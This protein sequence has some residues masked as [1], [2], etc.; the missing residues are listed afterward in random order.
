MQW[1]G[2]QEILINRIPADSNGHKW[3]AGQ[4][5]KQVAAI[6]SH[7]SSST[8]HLPLLV[9]PHAE[10]NRCYRNPPATKMVMVMV[11]GDG[12]NTFYR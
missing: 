1:M 4:A 5:G 8:S 11:K 9:S 2:R 10:Q 6:S 12:E 3:E 7:K